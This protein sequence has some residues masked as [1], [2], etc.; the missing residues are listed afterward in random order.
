M[1]SLRSKGVVPL[2]TLM[3]FKLLPAECRNP[4]LHR[5]GGGRFT[6]NPNVNFT[7]WAVCEQF[8]VG[9]WLCMKHPNSH[10]FKPC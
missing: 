8:F 5:V 4:V 9:D 3:V 6:W 10:S 1:K 2:I 7:D